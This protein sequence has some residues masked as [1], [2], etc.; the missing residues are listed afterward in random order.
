MT[1]RLSSSGSIGTTLLVVDEL[2]LLVVLALTLALLQSPAHSKKASTFQR[3]I[4]FRHASEVVLS[5][6]VRRHS[7]YPGDMLAL[8]VSINNKRTDLLSR[9]NTTS[10]W[11]LYITAQVS[12]LAIHTCGC[13]VGFR[14]PRV[15]RDR[16]LMYS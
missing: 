10:T 16:P 6:C 1:L 2:Q 5:F 3:R 13:D 15:L 12:T 8:D 9:G 7:M 11:P 14:F 4:D